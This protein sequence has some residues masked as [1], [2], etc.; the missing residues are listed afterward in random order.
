MKKIFLFLAAVTALISIAITA[1]AQS[2]DVGAGKAKYEQLCVT[3]H[4][5]SGKGDGPVGSSLNPK[6]KDLSKTAKSDADLKKTITQ[7]GA[8]TGL[9]PVMPAWGALL[10]EQEVSN[11]IAYIRTLK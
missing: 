9:S 1:K 8:A 4:G 2:G 3:C 7:G 5:P 11:I 6:P 10:K